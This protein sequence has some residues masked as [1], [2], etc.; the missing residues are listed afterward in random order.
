VDNK[1]ELFENFIT[2]RFTVWDFENWRDEGFELR[3]QA[4]K[5]GAVYQK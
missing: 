5:Q 2:S 4:P 1:L 3:D